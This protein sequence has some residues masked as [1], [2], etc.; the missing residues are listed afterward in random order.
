[1][2]TIETTEIRIMRIRDVL[3]HPVVYFTHYLYIKNLFLTV[4]GFNKIKWEI[5]FGRR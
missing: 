2:K 5:H 1:M 3:R 4:R